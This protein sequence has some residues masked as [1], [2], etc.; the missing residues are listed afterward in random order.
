LRGLT[1]PQGDSQELVELGVAQ[2]AGA[3]RGPLDRPGHKR[4][5]LRGVGVHQ[6][7]YLRQLLCRYGNKLWLILALVKT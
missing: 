5:S 6:A 3:S 2:L 7:K 1:L 4:Y